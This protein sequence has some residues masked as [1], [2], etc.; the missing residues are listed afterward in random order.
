MT[1]WSCYTRTRCANTTCIS[2]LKDAC[3]R[4]DKRYTSVKTNPGPGIDKSRP[5]PGIESTHISVRHTATINDVILHHFV[6]RSSS[7][8]FIYW[9]RLKPVLWRYQP[10]LHYRCAENGNSTVKQLDKRQKIR[11]RLNEPLEIICKWFFIQENI[12]IVI[13]P[14]KPILN[15]SNCPNRAFQVRVPGQDDKGGVCAGGIHTWR[16]GWEPFSRTVEVVVVVVVF[17][18]GWRRVCKFFSE[19]W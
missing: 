8:G 15:R 18:W 2:T 9:V 5:H 10:K 1:K 4:T 11:N 16:E 12:R 19:I 17:G 6:T 13:I 3:R 7:L 14:I